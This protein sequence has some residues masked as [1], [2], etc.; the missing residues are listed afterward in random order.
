MVRRAVASWRV[1]TCRTYASAD[2]TVAADV[3]PTEFRPS[4][5]LGRSAISFVNSGVRAKSSLTMIV[6]PRPCM[7]FTMSFQSSLQGTDD[8]NARVGDKWV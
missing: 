7:W 6:P 5:G 4:F 1:R 8:N 3:P 2:A